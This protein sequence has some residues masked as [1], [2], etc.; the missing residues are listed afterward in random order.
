AFVSSY[1]PTQMLDEAFLRQAMAYTFLHE[2]G[3]PII[4]DVLPPRKARQLESIRDLQAEL[5][6]LT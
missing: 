3:A 5:W 1:D 6:W 2:F 4:S